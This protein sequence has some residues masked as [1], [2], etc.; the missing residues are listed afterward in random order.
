VL[1]HERLDL[2]LLGI[3]LVEDL[4]RFVGPVVVADAGVVAPDDEVGAAVVLSYQRVKSGFLVP[5]ISDCG[6]VDR[7]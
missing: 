2:E 6:G 1:E 5:G 4:L 7:L 3:E